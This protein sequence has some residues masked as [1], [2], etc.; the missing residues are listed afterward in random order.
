MADKKISALS[1]ATTPLAGTEVLPIVQSG[2]TVKVAVD[3][4]TAG[5]TVSASVLN[6]GTTTSVTN[7]VL[8]TYGTPAKGARFETTTTTSLVEFQD[9]GTTNQPGLGSSGDDLILQV[10]FAT[11]AT[12]QN[13]TKDFLVASGNFVPSTAAKGVNFTAN[14]PAA[15]MTSQLLNWYEEGTWTPV[16]TVGFTTVGAT[17]LTGTYT[18]IG[19]SV[20]VRGTLQAATTLTSAGGNTRV[21]GFP[22][23][24]TSS[25]PVVFAQDNLVYPGTGF[26]AGTGAGL[27]NPAYTA[28]S[29][30]VV[31]TFT[32]TI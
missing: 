30:T 22:F 31:F 12:L 26:F 19:R 8:H 27:Y 13:S 14:T 5:K 10:G 9:S 15:G 1:A 20:F 28:G 29:N 23:T 7:R 16:L 32:Y 2:T 25:T 17:T 18:R 11:K 24:S 4:L 6:L 3:D 21:T